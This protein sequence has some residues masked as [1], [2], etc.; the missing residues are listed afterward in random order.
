MEM[1]ELQWER[2]V[3][4]NSI[5]EVL[6]SL[7]EKLRSLLT[8][9]DV[10]TGRISGVGEVVML[11]CRTGGPKNTAATTDTPELLRHMFL[12]SHGSHEPIDNLIFTQHNRQQHGHGCI[13]SK[14]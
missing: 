12:F 1:I 10:L 9:T 14:K 4:N 3:R 6:A 7:H 11:R 5:G 13:R 8:N 2:N